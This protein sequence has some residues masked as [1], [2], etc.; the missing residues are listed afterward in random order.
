MT[1]IKAIIDSE[2][3]SGKI[4]RDNEITALLKK[5]GITIARRTIAKYRE[6][7]NIPPSSVRNK[8]TKLY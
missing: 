8:T 4:F 2:N 1:R 5:Q 6:I 3:S 7:M